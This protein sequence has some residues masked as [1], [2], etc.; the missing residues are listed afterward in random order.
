[1]EPGSV[2]HQL[3]LRLTEQLQWYSPNIP[4]GNYD[5]VIVQDYSYS[6]RF[7]WDTNAIC[8]T[9]S[10]RI[11]KAVPV[12]RSFVNEFLVVR[13]QQQGGEHRLAYVTFSQSG[14]NRIPFMNDTN[15]ALAA[16]KAQIGDLASPR[17]IPNADLPGNTN[18]AAGLAGAATYLNAARTVDSHGQPVRLAVLLLTDGL[19]NVFNDGGYQN[20]TNRFNQAPFFCGE[21]AADMD[22]PTVQATC[23][24]DAE[25]PDIN[26][27]PLPPL[28]AMVK[29]ANDVRT[30]RP[31]VFYAVTLGALFGLTPVDMHLNQVAPNHYYMANNPAELEALVNSI[32]QELG[33]PCTEAVAAPRIA[34]GA[35]V[36]IAQQGGG[37]VGTFT[38]DAQGQVAIP[39]LL[40]GAYTLTAQ[41]LGVIAPQDPL[42][43]ARDYTRMIVDTGSSV[44]VSAVA[45]TMPDADYSFPA[46]TLIINPELNAQC[47][48]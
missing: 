42:A 12:V 34:A 21:T 4:G 31:V 35:T 36:T 10:R 33:E 26:P 20:I 22:N 7:C 5:I 14:T 38:A 18:T 30:A 24:S 16:F 11:D 40:P 15:A 9:G 27:K 19:A 45:F 28:K 3:S 23:P 44:P 32:A 13:N 47:P 39:D 46:I 1:M 2:G 37:T 17:T 48:D 25:F 41:H 8:A 29:V 6:M 43:I